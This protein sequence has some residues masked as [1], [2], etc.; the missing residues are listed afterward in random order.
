MIN[1]RKLAY[2]VLG[3][4]G[5]CSSCVSLSHE[6]KASDQKSSRVGRVQAFA[7]HVT[8]TVSEVSTDVLPIVGAVGREVIL[9]SKSDVPNVAQEL[10]H[11]VSHLSLI[12]KPRQP[13]P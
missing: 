4:M 11:Q 7:K 2:S 6:T 5:C 9:E 1:F 13:S 3:V 8:N 12:R 10:G